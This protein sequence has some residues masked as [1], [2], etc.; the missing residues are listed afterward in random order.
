MTGLR[1]RK[2]HWVGDPIRS[3]N[4]MILD[5]M[6]VLVQT[7][8]W[9]SNLDRAT[10]QHALLPVTD[11][12]QWQRFV[13]AR[14]LAEF[15]LPHEPAAFDRH[16]FGQMSWL[17]SAQDQAD[18]IHGDSLI[19]AARAQGQEAEYKTAHLEI[20]KAA[21][22]SQRGVSDQPILK[23]GASDFNDVARSAGK[24]ACRM[25]A[26]EV[27]VGRV[28]FW[29]GLIRV[30]HQGNWPMGLLPSGEVAVL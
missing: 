26:S 19:A 5:E 27:V 3:Q 14:T 12:G 18:P 8:P 7:T 30:Y 13:G 11:L 2:D 4:T 23:V 25:A 20:F 17:P 6:L 22:A 24:Y 9:F 10:A 16:P 1:A 21:A 15:S 29:C 28:G